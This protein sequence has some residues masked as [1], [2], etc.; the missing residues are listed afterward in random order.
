MRTNV[1]INDNI[2]YLRPF[3]SRREIRVKAGTAQCIFSNYKSV[4]N[5]SRI[6]MPNGIGQIGKVFR[7]EICPKNFLFRSR[8][9]EQMEI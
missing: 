8:G 6:S 7:N 3:I 5:L 4:L 9:F 2:S 1:E